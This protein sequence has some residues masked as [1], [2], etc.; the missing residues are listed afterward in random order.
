[1]RINS[2][3]K[4]IRLVSTVRV[5]CP[6]RCYSAV[7][8]VP[9]GKCYIS[10]CGSNPLREALQGGRATDG[11]LRAALVRQKECAVSKGRPAWVAHRLQGEIDFLA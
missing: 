7:K 1:M 6:R 4:I 9:D 2:I 3:S 8:T 5:C 10:G 11:D